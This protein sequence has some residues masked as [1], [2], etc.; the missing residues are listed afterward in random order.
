MRLCLFVLVI[1]CLLLVDAAKESRH[2]Q[3]LRKKLL[4]KEKH[5]LSNTIG[6]DDHK[7]LKHKLGHWGEHWG[8]KVK[9]HQHLGLLGHRGEHWSAVKKNKP[10]KWQHKDTHLQDL[11]Y[12]QETEHKP[13]HV[14]DTP[15]KLHHHD[16]KSQHHKN[17]HHEPSKAQLHRVS[18]QHIQPQLNVPL[19]T[20]VKT[21]AKPKPE[22]YKHKNKTYK[23]KKYPKKYSKKYQKKY[24]KYMKNKK[25]Y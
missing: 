4:E 3:R 20:S 15:K 22:N 10:E 23:Y 24:N 18:L 21:T 12:K 13:R 5:L 9:K 14:T 1:S 16:I 2:K 7:S 11:T 25:N 6:Q 8:D 19:A 17:I